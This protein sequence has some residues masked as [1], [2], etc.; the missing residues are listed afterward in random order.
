MCIFLKHT[1]NILHNRSQWVTKHL[2]KLKKIEIISSIFSD[3]GGMKLKISNRKKI[4]KFT[5]RWKLN[6]TLLKNC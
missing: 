1:W 2:K 5:N 3:H 4:E 6:T